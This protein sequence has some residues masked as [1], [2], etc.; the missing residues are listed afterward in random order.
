MPRDL[1]KPLPRES[2]AEGSAT[3][4]LV[5]GVSVGRAES[6]RRSTG[7]S[8]I[9]FEAP[10]PTIVDV[11]GGASGTFDTA[12]LA[13]DATF[14]L[15][16]AVF[17]AG[18]S[19]YGLD[20]AAGVR[21]AVLARGG[22]VRVF[23]NPNP[24]VPISGAILFDLPSKRGGIPDYERLGYRAA[25]SA[26]HA[27]VDQGRVGAGAG[28]TIGKYLGRDR[29]ALGGLGSAASE[30]SGLGRIGALVAVNSVGAVRDPDTGRLV[31]GPRGP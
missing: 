7:V 15:R 28:A 13:L 14:G 3:L 2:L 29:A 6:P 30:I 18:G 16:E 24:I 31:E 4:T 19:L 9:V 23:D 21:R 26:S 5:R 10:V 8:A 12:S 11:R 22:G 17:F 1:S 27:P 25:R 20:A